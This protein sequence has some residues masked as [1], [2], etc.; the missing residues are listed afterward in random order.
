M[1]LSPFTTVHIV[2]ISSF[3]SPTGTMAKVVSQETYD[4]VVLENIV[5][6]EMSCDE[7]HVESQKEFDAQVCMYGKCAAHQCSA[8]RFNTKP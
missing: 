6:F 2:T 1:A 3:P 4:N 5:D 8:L 7:A